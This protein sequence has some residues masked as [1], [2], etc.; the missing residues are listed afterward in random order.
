MKLFHN[1]AEDYRRNKMIY[2]LCIP[3]VLYFI[4]FCYLPMGGIAVAFQKYS[5]AKG[6]FG[7]QFI[8]L[9]N[10]IEF[11]NSYYFWRLLRNTF[12]L[13]FYTL[14][15]GFPAPIIF[16]L[17]LNEVKNKFF[18]RTIQTMSYM[19]YFISIVVVCGLII[20]FTNAGGIIPQIL[21]FFGFQN[22]SLMADPKY[23][24]IIYVISDIWRNLGY[25]SI[26]YLAALS[27]VDQTLYEA[28]EIDG[29]SKLKQVINIT[30]PC[31]APTIIIMLILR[32]G[33]MFALGFEKVMLLYNPA[34]Y[35]TADIISTFVYRK[36]FEDF[37]FGFSTAVDLFNSFINCGLLLV[38]NWIS[39]KYTDTSLF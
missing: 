27:G 28:A 32:I 13:S 35:E 12:L 14:L 18:K 26:V 17:L 3:I 20:D 4:V 5:L 36:G 25:S 7:S 21:S 30:L 24:R 8:G 33:T 11:F 6:I 38:T 23:F 39:R 9:K 34:T 16:A 29:A 22:T 1:I 19:P 10:F 37:N 15:F 31:I 2:F